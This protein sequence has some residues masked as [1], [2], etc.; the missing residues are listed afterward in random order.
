M[1]RTTTWCRE[2]AGIVMIVAA[3][4]QAVRLWKLAKA[5]MQG[6]HSGLDQTLIAQADA[7]GRLVIDLGASRA[8]AKVQVTILPGSDLEAGREERQE[9]LREVLGSIDDPAFKRPEQDY[10]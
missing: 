3:R 8:N 2:G 4:R 6:L 5:A 1:F 10:I 7:A 9:R